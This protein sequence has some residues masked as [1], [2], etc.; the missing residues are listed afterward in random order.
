MKG[1]R[2]PEYSHPG[3]TPERQPNANPSSIDSQHPNKVPVDAKE[4]FRIADNEIPRDAAVQHQ[5]YAEEQNLSA[6]RHEPS[7]PF[8]MDVASPI[9]EGR[10]KKEQERLRTFSIPADPLEP[11]LLSARFA[12]LMTHLQG[13][14]KWYEREF[15]ANTDL[16]L[17]Y[18]FD[19][20]LVLHQR[21]AEEH[22]EDAARVIKDTIGIIEDLCMAL[23]TK[24]TGE[25][26]QRRDRKRHHRRSHGGSHGQEE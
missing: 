2:Q 9:P 25:Y 23:R 15:T 13:F 26:P 3:N 21:W 12:N 24:R 5:M 11:E 16:P 20:T 6:T 8:D 4:Q 18:G 19:R 22:P 17:A 1:E 10:P 14:S 7:E